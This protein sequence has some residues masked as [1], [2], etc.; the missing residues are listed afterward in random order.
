MYEALSYSFLYEALSY[1]FLFLFEGACRYCN[2]RNVT[3][4]N[5]SKNAIT[6]SSS[7]TICEH[8]SSIPINLRTHVE[9]LSTYTPTKHVYRCPF[10]DRDG[11]SPEE[12]SVPLTR[13]SSDDLPPKTVSRFFILFHVSLFLSRS[14]SLD[15]CQSVSMHLCMYAC[16][17]A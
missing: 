9:H 13:S 1:S 7:Y 16:M 3:R 11:R 2:M 6:L 14:L 8:T 4:G 17:Y 12:E 5:L 10:R 15:V